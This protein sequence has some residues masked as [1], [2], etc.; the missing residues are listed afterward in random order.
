VPDL[1]DDATGGSRPGREEQWGPITLYLVR[2]AQEAHDWAGAERLQRAQV[3]W[4]R[5]QAAPLLAGD[6]DLSG[7][8]TVR[9]LAVSLESLGSVL[10]EQQK[11]ACVEFYEEGFQLC[12]RIGD[13]AEAAICAFNLGH[14]YTALPALRDLDAAEHWYRRSLTLRA[15]GDRKGRGGCLAQLGQVAYERFKEAKEQTGEG[16]AQARLQYLN[17][18][19]RYYHQALDLLPADA[20]DDLAATHNALGVIYDD[21]GDVA[22]AVQHFND[23]VRYLE[24]AGD[25]YHAGIVRSNLALPLARQGRWTDALAYARAAL[26]DFQ[27]Y[28]G[29]AAADE[30]DTLQLIADIE[31]A[32]RGEPPA[33]S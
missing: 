1:V 24:A 11:L 10:R 8:K 29:R 2:L 4:L 27:R 26:R 28:H 21:A 32:Q 33:S 31:K 16:A 18:A 7:D 17:D 19:L 15:E 12:K 23:A 6:G 13:D 5:Q 30:E 14:A 20:V 25:F 22:R 3:A 9:S